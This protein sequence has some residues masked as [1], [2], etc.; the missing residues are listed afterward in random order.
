MMFKNKQNYG[1]RGQKSG[2]LCG[3][4]LKLLIGKGHKWALWV[5]E[6]KFSFIRVVVTYE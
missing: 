1:D 2:Y 6:I 3:E 5:V 4:E